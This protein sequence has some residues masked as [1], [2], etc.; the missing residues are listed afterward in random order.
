MASA[1]AYTPRVPRV[2]LVVSDAHIGFGPPEVERAFHRFLEHVPDEAD[3]LVIN[4]DLFEFWF[5]YRSVVPRA[6]FPTLGA[7]L[8]VR[9]AGVR[10]TV[11]GGNHDRWGGAFWEQEL[12]AEFHRVEVELRLARFRALVRH[13]DGIGGVGWSSR[14]FHTAIGHPVTERIFRLLHPDIGFAVVRRMSPHLAGKR[15]AAADRQRLAEQQEGYARQVLE[16]Q[17]GIELV[18]L[19][20]THV[21]RL[22]AIAP[23]RWLLNPGAWNEGYRYARIDAEGPALLTFS[24]EREPHQ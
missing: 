11:V 2:T 7:L 19:G 12:G 14:A 9:H 24:P 10:L 16:R 18:V 15:P 4:G 17:P 6:V 23:R 8:R 22:T 13:G 5:E 21:P 1:V 20:H 3:H